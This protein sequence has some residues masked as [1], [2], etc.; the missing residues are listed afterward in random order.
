LNAKT[1]RQF[2]ITSPRELHASC[3]KFSRARLRHGKPS[4][5][6]IGIPAASAVGIVRAKEISEIRL[7][8]GTI[9]VSFAN[10]PRT[11]KLKTLKA[12]TV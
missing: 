10:C 2:Q 12:V 9:Q 6:F 3:V 1:E 4:G 5:D 11:K 8:A 7:T